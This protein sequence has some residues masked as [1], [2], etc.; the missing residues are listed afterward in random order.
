[1]SPHVLALPARTTKGDA[2]SSARSAVPIALFFECRMNNAAT[3]LRNERP[4]DS[5]HFK[6]P[7]YDFSV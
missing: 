3:E 2:S 4:A 1:M 7:T 6:I 5:R